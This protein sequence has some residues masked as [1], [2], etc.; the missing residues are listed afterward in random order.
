MFINK[1][2][3]YIKIKFGLFR[4]HHYGNYNEDVVFFVFRDNSPQAGVLALWFRVCCAINYAY[5]KGFIPIID[6]KDSNLTSLADNDLSTKHNVW[7]FY[8]NQSVSYTL[9]DVY[10]SKNVIFCP[11]IWSK[12]LS[13]FSPY[14]SESIYNIS[15]IDSSR[16]KVF[17]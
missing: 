5:K 10:K 14:I 2:L 15:L 1:V 12:Y 7:N 8:F 17:I 16:R 13:P 9:D 4:V 6:F 3:E 11:C